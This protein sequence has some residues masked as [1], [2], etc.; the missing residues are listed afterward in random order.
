MTQ[1]KVASIA[2]LVVAL[3]ACG[4]TRQAR[5]VTQSGFLGDYSMLKPGPDGGARLVYQNPSADIKSYTKILLMPVTIWTGEGSAMNDLSPEDRKMVADRLFTVLQERLAKDYTLVQQPGPDTMRI[6]AALTTADSSYPVMDTISTLLPIG[7]G[8]ST[9]K[10][11]ATGKPAFVGE[12]SVEVR[13]TDA[14][15][16]T[17]LFEA[18]DSRVGTKNPMGIWD[19]WEDVDEAFVYWANRMGY[20]LCVERGA[21]GCVAP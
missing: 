19:K 6:A 2:V 16:G 4:V 18:V 11:I 3:L 5:D 10:A 1:L 21:T 14:Q 20:K 13:V 12:A 7:L 15:T 17:V 9:L 8:L